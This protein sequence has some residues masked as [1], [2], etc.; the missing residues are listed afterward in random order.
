M[1][2]LFI[3]V[4]I[5]ILG[6]MIHTSKI[7]IEIENLQ[8][9][10]ESSPKINED[11][12]IYVYLLIFQKIKLFKKD[13]KNLDFK[14][15]KFQNKD[16]DIKFLKDK[17]FKINYKELLQNI[18]IDIVKI[19]LDTKIG[20]QNAAVTAILVGIISSVLGIIIRKPKYQIIP[21]YSNKNLLK[22]K[23][24][25]IFTIYLMHYIYSV[26]SKRKSSVLKNKME[27]KYE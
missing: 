20:T 27:V 19:T 24:D 21:V 14:K 8:I 16:I 22:I 6:L 4:A 18:K 3:F 2:F 13:I 1:F 15:I 11:S 12:K 9:D 26:I 5:L 10:T 25:G 7:G 23:L 17:D